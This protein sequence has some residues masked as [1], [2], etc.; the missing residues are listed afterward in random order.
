MFPGQVV[1]TG[2]LYY[3][4]VEV[5]TGTK[6]IST[7][8]MLHCIKTYNSIRCFEG[9]IR[10]PGAHQLSHAAMISLVSKVHGKNIQ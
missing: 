3:Y 2:A 8:H 7:K 5:T 4:Q 6:Q 10:D 1:K 9:T